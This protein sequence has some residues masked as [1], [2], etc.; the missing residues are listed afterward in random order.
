MSSV[1]AFETP[2]WRRQLL[3]LARQ[4][5]QR[6]LGGEAKETQPRLNIPGHAGGAFVTFWNGSTLRGCMG[7]FQ[8]TDDICS[9]IEDVTVNSLTDPRFAANPITLEELSSLNIEISVLTSPVRTHAPLS[10]VPGRHGIIVRLAGRSGC[11]LP[12]VA[13]ERGWNAEE[14]LS[15]CCTM[16]AGL[17]AD[18]WRNEKA[19]VLLFESDS[20]SE[21]QYAR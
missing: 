10:L 1:A 6:R 14:F 21:M 3:T 2:V 19:E 7:T 13:N 18:A 15:T 17:P 8:A 4:T 11:F 20:F 9:T 16:K 12:Q 5:A